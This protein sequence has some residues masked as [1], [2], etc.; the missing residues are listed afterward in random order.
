LNIGLKIRSFVA[1]EYKKAI[2]TKQKNFKLKGEKE[3]KW[4]N[5]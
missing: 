4:Q 5:S 2:K 3:R 1:I